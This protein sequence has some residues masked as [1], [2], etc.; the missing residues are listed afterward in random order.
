[1]ANCFIMA[2][3]SVRCKLIL[4]NSNVFWTYLH[5]VLCLKLLDDDLKSARNELLEAE[6]REITLKGRISELAAMEASLNIRIREVNI[7]GADV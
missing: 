6:T 7:F 4:P 2:A 1:M 5:I 3:P